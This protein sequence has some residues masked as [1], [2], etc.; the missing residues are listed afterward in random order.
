MRFFKAFFM[1][2]LYIIGNGLDISLGMKT[3]YQSFY[4]YYQS[5][6]SQDSDIIQMKKSIKA[7]RFHTWADLEAGLGDYTKTFVFESSFLKC[8]NDIKRALVIYLSEQFKLRDYSVQN[9]FANDFYSPDDYLDDQVKLNYNSFLS[10]FSP[11]QIKYN[12]KIV[13]LN[14]TNTIEDIFGKVRAET[15]SL[16]HLHGSLTEGMVMGVS[17]VNQIAN[18]AFRDNRDVV[19]DFVK[20]SYNDACLNNNNVLCERW[21]NQADLIV[22]FGTS[23]GETDRK[24]WRLIGSQI[25]KESRN[26]MLILFVYDKDKDLKLH[27]NHRLRWTEQYQEILLSKLEI[28]EEKK[29]L[30][31]TR[32][33]IG[34]N[35]PI[36]QLSRLNKRG[37]SPSPTIDNKHIVL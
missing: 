23:L 2:V 10:R 31:L 15:P 27:P 1:N 8:L 3:D 14:Y 35:K 5:L 13:T 33:C 21:I 4:D 12:V 30:V 11:A 22:L 6:E 24:W 26:L 32:L 20:P 19:E 34:I 17:D 29:G 25:Q 36:F 28:P 37:V 18:E 9:H 16:L 7:G